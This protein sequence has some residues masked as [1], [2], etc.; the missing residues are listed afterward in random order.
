MRPFLLLL[1]FRALNVAAS[2]TEP[3][4][5]AVTPSPGWSSRFDE[6]VYFTPRPCLGTVARRRGATSSDT[7]CAVTAATFVAPEPRTQVPRLVAAGDTGG[8]LY[9]LSLTGA[10]LAESQAAG[11][12]VTSIVS[13]QLGR[14]RAAVAT[15]HTDSTLRVRWMDEGDA[16]SVDDS[17]PRVTLHAPVAHADTASSST[18]RIDALHVIPLAGG[19]SGR[20][21][22][23]CRSDGWLTVHDAGTTAILAAGQVLPQTRF[24]AI[25]SASSSIQTAAAGLMLH[26]AH[27]LGIGVAYMYPLLQ[28]A[29]HAQRRSNAS[30]EQQAH[31]PLRV[32][33]VSDSLPCTGLDAHESLSAFVFSSA[34][35]GAVPL[36]RAWA[37]TNSSMLVRLA[38]Y[39]PQTPQRPSPPGS[40]GTS[41][42]FAPRCSVLSRRPLNRMHSN[43]TAALV[44]GGLPISIAQLHPATLVVASAAGTWMYDIAASLRNSSALPVLIDFT[45][46]FKLYA[47]KTPTMTGVA[48]ALAPPPVLVTSRYGLALA[49]ALSTDAPLSV[50]QH[51]AGLRAVEATASAAG[52]GRS[53]ESRGVWDSTGSG[54]GALFGRPWVLIL[55]GVL[56]WNVFKA[57]SKSLDDG[58]YRPGQ[59]MGMQQRRNPSPM[60]MPPRSPF[61]AGGGSPARYRG[62]RS[63]SAHSADDADLWAALQQ[64][65][66]V[67]D[68]RVDE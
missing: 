52:A 35:G 1:A 48:S 29:T 6:T 46:A 40:A 53:T 30:R 8:R 7:T 25:R 56:A 50:F 9:V 16:L 36:A 51:T 31:H 60:M 19:P 18:A 41:V 54:P 55:G 59:R 67:T 61:Q 12:S 26:Y 63:G 38:V 37:V 39:Y 64:R 24:L 28:Q 17:T 68:M 4:A 44:Q 22:V 5:V 10:V 20:V 11:S 65:M 23:A 15:G 27:A 66:A 3:V 58:S 42:G 14:S 57:N 47:A 2:N 43:G 21:L 45:P 34:S 62:D 32:V 33:R 49:L 13:W